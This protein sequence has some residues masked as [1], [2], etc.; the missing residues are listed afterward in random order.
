MSALPPFAKSLG[1]RT[2]AIE[3]VVTTVIA[4]LIEHGGNVRVRCST[5]EVVVSIVDIA[6]GS[7]CPLRRCAR[8]VTPTWHRS[9]TFMGVY[10]D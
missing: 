1:R 10:T 4:P 7:M 6:K 9:G 3:D 2:V 8:G 5:S